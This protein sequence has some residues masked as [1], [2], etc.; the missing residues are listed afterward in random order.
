MISSADIVVASKLILAAFLG[1]LVG[2][3]REHDRRPAGL[4]TYIL[5]CLGAAM[6]GII[7]STYFTTATADVSRIWQ[8]IITGVGFLGAGAVIK[9]EH[10]VHGL[11]T[12][13]GIWAVAGIGLAV[14]A[15]NFFM[16]LVAEAI[17]LITLLILRRVEHH[18]SNV[19]TTP[20][21]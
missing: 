19:D 12:A 9:D 21:P 4:R 20:H 15:G 5:I 10:S 1:G 6:F 13:A 7:G 17:I 18:F 14:A 3:E 8:N 2:L 16:A 11:T